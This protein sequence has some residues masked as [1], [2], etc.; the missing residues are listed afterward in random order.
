MCCTARYG[1][2]RGDGSARR[3]TGDGGI[4]AGYLSDK[5]GLEKSTFEA[6]R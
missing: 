3:G 1:G 5:L 4:D 2:H 6:K